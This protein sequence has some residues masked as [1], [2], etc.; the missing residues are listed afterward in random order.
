M[1][2]NLNVNKNQSHAGRWRAVVATG[3]VLLTGLFALRFAKPDVPSTI[4]LLAGPTGSTFYQDGVRYR[5]ILARYGVTVELVATGGSV[6]NLKLLAAGCGA[7]AGFAEAVQYPGDLQGSGPDRLATL[8]SLYVEPFWVFARRGLEVTQVA[9][10]KGLAIAPGNPGSGVRVF[11][12]ALLKANGLTGNVTL[13]DAEALTAADLRTA[14]ERGRVDALFAAGQPD[15]PLIDAL[16]R[17]P[18][19]LP[20]SLRRIDSLEYRFP[21][22]MRLR[23]PQGAQDIALN[24]PASDLDLIG[25]SVQLVVPASLPGALSDLLLMAAREVHGERGPFAR[26]GEF[27][28]ANLVSLPLSRAAVRY[29]ERGPSPLWRVLPFRLATLVDRFMWVAASVA[30]AAL[31]LFGLL[32]K[33]L[34]FPYKRASLALYQRL[35]SAEKALGP[36]ADKTTLLAELDEIDRISATLRVP[37]SLRPDYLGLRQS[38]HDVREHVSSL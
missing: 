32:P 11:A 5:D 31:A 14:V 30:S 22:I 21:G 19:F 35:E 2:M 38:I 7:C 37:K 16:L 33:L 18:D 17:W 3:I 27:P 10:L 23:F 28:N 6:A 36:G 25:L 9:D 8:G 15:S 13:V 20:V 4:T 34:S 24:I 12:D 1:L 26:H 29:Y